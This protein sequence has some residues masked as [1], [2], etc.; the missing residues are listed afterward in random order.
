MNLK[1]QILS[2]CVVALQKKPSHVEN[3][4]VV[5]FFRSRLAWLKTL[6]F[7]VGD[8][9]NNGLKNAVA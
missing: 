7:L 3:L 1:T 6:R 4:C 8:L 2:P 5:G 9:N